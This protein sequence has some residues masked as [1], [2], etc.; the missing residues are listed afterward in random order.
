MLLPRPL[1]P[2]LPLFSSSPLLLFSSLFSRPLLPPSQVVALNYQTH[3]EPVW[4][5]QGKFMDNG[6]CGYVLK[7]EFLLPKGGVETVT[8]NPELAT[9]PKQRLRVEVHKG[10]KLII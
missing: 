7:P 4:L 3:G 5:N 1:H 8:F 9:T 10:G 2:S 6:G